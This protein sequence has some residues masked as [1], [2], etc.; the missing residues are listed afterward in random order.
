MK[1]IKRLHAERPLGNDATCYVRNR[2]TV[3]STAST[4]G[5]S[6]P[7]NCAAAQPR[8]KKAAARRR[9]RGWGCGCTPFLGGMFLGLAF[10]LAIYF[11]A[12]GRTNILLTGHRL[13]L[14]L[15]TRLGAVTQWCSSSINPLK[16]Y[17]AMLVNPA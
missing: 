7:P 10:L 15:K 9:S 16:P 14:R 11:L 17:V 5:G 3:S 1:S 4:P 8:A 6:T 2:P 12:P 13:S